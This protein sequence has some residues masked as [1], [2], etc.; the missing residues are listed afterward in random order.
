MTTR[1]RYVFGGADFMDDSVTETPKF[2]RRLVTIVSGDVVSYTRLMGADDEATLSHLLPLRELIADY[3]G[4]HYGTVFGVA[5]DAFMAEF[6]SPVHAIRCAAD[7]QAEIERRNELLPADRRLRYRLG[8]HLGDVIASSDA[9]FGDAVNIAARL[10]AQAEPGHIVISDNV[11]AHVK[12]MV[13]L[14]FQPLGQLHLKG[15]RTPIVSYSANVVN[16]LAPDH[17]DSPFTVVDLSQPVPGFGDRP[18]LAVLPLKIVGTSEDKEYVADGLVD[19][20]IAGLMKMR[21]LPVISRHT[22]FYHRNSS[23]DTQ[24]IGRAIGAGYLVTGS[25]R[26]IQDDIYLH[27]NLVDTETGHNLWGNKYN[28][29]FHDLPSLQDE[30]TASL[31]CTIDN[32]IGKTEQTRAQ[33]RKPEDLDTWQL[34]RRGTSHLH[35]L[36]KEDAAKAREFFEAALERDPNSVEAHVQMAWWYFWD[37]WTQRG[38]H[39]GLHKI[40]KLARRAMHLDPLDGRG[41]M[42]L[43]IGQLMMGKPELGRTN[44]FEAKRLNP[45]LVSAHSTYGSTYILSGEPEK[46]IDP[47]LLAIR[48][49]PR[50]LFMFHY[51]GELAVAF[52]MQGEWAKAIEFAERSLQFRPGYW[53][54]KAVLIASLVRSNR[55]AKALEIADN[56]FVT[57]AAKQINWLPFSERK[58]N[59]YLIEGLEMAHSREVITA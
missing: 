5:G 13:D 53:Y 49:N 26:F 4:R 19:D 45:S 1:V 8:L 34:I 31:V 44:L 9:L 38:D 22:S 57:F 18:A 30:I 42:M 36:T 12:G 52:H 48:L 14:E 41:H 2:R 3:V 46:A 47:L 35:L 24:A 50:C 7:L 15:V 17:V 59:K 40:E 23:L 25:I 28:I 11:W 54:A 51:L 27:I 20:I 37:V 58:W 43:G 55:V 29:C 39:S 6:V 32:E 21:W 56:D 10:Q 16:R 33:K